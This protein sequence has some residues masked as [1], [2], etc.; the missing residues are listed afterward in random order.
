MIWDDKLVESMSDCR[1]RGHKFES[2]LGHITF[3]AIDHEI[4]SV[5]ILHLQLI[6]KGQLSVTGEKC[7]H[8]YWL[9]RGIWFQ[10]KKVVRNSEYLKIWFSLF[11]TVNI[12]NSISLRKLCISLKSIKESRLFS[13][14]KGLSDILRDICTSTN[15]I[16]RI[17]EKINPTD[18]FH[19]WIC[20]LILEVRDILKIFWKG[21]ETAPSSLQ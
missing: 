16:C 3:M 2:Q 18:T 19:K 1:S 15:Q 6:Q 21:G 4:I 14:S 7:V 17:E 9:T 8:K 5:V 12:W 20:N 10:E 13:K 11:E